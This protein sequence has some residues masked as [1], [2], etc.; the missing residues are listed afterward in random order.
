MTFMPLEAEERSKHGKIRWL[1]WEGNPSSEKMTSEDACLT[2]VQGIV[3]GET[4]NLRD[5]SFRDPDSFR[6]GQLRTR[7][8]LWEKI[9]AG[10]EP[11]KDVLEWLEHGVDVKKFMKP[12]KGSFM[13]IKYES[14]EPPTMIFKNHYSCKQFSK[15]VTETILQR[16]ETG[17]I[18]VWGKVGEVPPPHLVLPMTIEPQKPRLCTDARFLNLW[19]ADTPFSLETL[20]GV[21]RFVYPNSYMSKIDDKSGYDH[22]LLSTSSQQ[23]FGIEWLGW[24]LVGVT[25]PFGWKNSPFVYQ[26]VGLGPTNF[27]RSL[28]VACSLYI[29]DRLNG[30]LFAV[31]GF[32]SRPLSERTSEYSYQSAVAALYIVCSVLVNLGYFLGLSKCVLVPVTRICYLGMIVDSVAQAFCIPEDKKMK[33]AQLREQILLRESTIHLKSLQRLM[34]KCNSFSLAFPATKFYI[35]EMAASISKASGGGEVNFSPNLREE[36]MFWRFLDSWEKAIRW[37]SERHVAISLTSD[38]SSF[39]WGVVIHLPSGTVSVGDYWE[40]TVR[41]EHINVK[42][43][44]AVL[45]GLQSLPESVSDCRIDAQVDSMVVLHAWSGRGPRSRKLTQ[46][47]QLIFQFLVDRNMSLEMSFVPSHLNEADWF[48]RRLSRSDAMLSPRS[49]EIVQRS[50]GGING[51]DLDLMSLDSN[52]QRDWSGNPLKHFT[53]YPTPGSSGVNV[54]NQDLSVCDGDRVNAYVFPPFALIGPLLRFLIS[55]DAV[56]T[57]VVP[58]MS[59]LPGWWPLL[60]AV[61]SNNV[62]VAEKGSLDALLLP[63]KDGFRPG[64]SPYSLLAF[65]MGKSMS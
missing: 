25:L 35:R 64:S 14:A 48:S 28:G 26:T 7:I 42:E 15:F 43:M 30:E 3:A 10:Y 40:E 46:I 63:S 47:S 61:S 37:R 11:A 20:V 8:E 51:H 65:R 31:K 6:S 54:F 29:D 57:V 12:F 16:I 18:R 39:R 41:N 1:S 44:W 58:L 36:I 50:F 19:M 52:V 62:L 9:L 60:N 5:L 17:A 24:W 59:P 13:G 56:V 33:F 2:H 53:P 45:K 23:F 55:V 32:W 34:G 21:P 27:F 49:W 38:S 22:I 4:P